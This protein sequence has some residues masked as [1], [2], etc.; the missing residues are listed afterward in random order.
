MAAALLAVLVGL[1]AA[2]DNTDLSAL[3]QP[4]GG[5]MSGLLKARARWISRDSI[6][7]QPQGMAK[8]KI[9]VV[10]C[11]ITRKGLSISTN[12]ESSLRKTVKFFH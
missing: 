9:V 6:V 8:T 5:K 1:T 7:W 4:A 3:G 12:S 2:Q 11:I 10:D